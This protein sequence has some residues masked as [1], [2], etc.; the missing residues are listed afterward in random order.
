MPQG[1][2]PHFAGT[3]H[4]NRLIAKMIEDLADVVHR[5]TGNGDASPGDTGF[6]ADAFGG[7]E[8]VL[9]EQVQKRP[10]RAAFMGQLISPLDLSRDLSFA[11]DQAVQ[12]SCH[13]EQMMD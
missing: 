9:K 12:T 3:N 11:D 2:L 13:A 5:G 1:K 7:L 4:Q 10:N 6:A 8:R